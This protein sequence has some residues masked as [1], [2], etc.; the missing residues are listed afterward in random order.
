MDVTAVLL[1]SP[2]LSTSYYL[3]QACF[4]LCI[5][6]LGITQAFKLCPRSSLLS[7]I[8]SVY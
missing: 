2:G 1:C 8:V 5:K 6:T 7:I 4:A 3:L